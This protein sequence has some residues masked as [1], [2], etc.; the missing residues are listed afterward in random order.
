MHCCVQYFSPRK[1]HHQRLW[2]WLT[3]IG[4]KASGRLLLQNSVSAHHNVMGIPRTESR[5]FPSSWTPMRKIVFLR[6]LMAFLRLSRCHPRDLETIC[7]LRI[8]P[9]CLIR[10][11]VKLFSKSTVHTCELNSS[12]IP[13]ASRKLMPSITVCLLVLYHLGSCNLTRGGTLSSC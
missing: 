2:S 11:G 7:L 4:N 12:S 10:H 5:A 1:T 3:R 6:L 9:Q 8:C 13:G